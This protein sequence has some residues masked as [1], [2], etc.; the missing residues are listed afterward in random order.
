MEV[1]L[2][3]EKKERKTEREREIE[4]EG[5]DT[6]RQLAVPIIISVSSFRMEMNFLL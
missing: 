6:K 1:L 3:K 4:R 2:S 5:K